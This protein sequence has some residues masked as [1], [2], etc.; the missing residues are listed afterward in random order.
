MNIV[1]T[2]CLKINTQ[3]VL[4]NIHHI[5]KGLFAFFAAISILISI[6]VYASKGD[7][8]SKEDAVIQGASADYHFAFAFCILAMLA[9]LGAGA[10]MM[11]EVVKA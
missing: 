7:E 10:I 11:I 6:A 2:A 9:A 1:R 5:C 3:V 8:L 4:Q